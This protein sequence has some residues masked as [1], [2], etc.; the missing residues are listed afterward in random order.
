M[1]HVQHMNSSTQV[2]IA[3]YLK[4]PGRKV[5]PPERCV[6][7]AKRCLGALPALSLS[8]YLALKCWYWQIPRHRFEALICV[9]WPRFLMPLVNVLISVMPFEAVN[10]AWWHAEPP[11]VQCLSRPSMLVYRVLLSHEGMF[12]QVVLCVCDVTFFFSFSDMFF[13][14]TYLTYLTHDNFIS[15]KSSCICDTPKNLQTHQQCHL[16]ASTHPRNMKINQLGESLGDHVPKISRVLSRV[17]RYR[18]GPLGTKAARPS[19]DLP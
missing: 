12:M 6:Y 9:I 7:D 4:A 11:I 1:M 18:L 19:K 8:L 17:G 10:D 16:V 14:E 13:F 5:G 2:R 3:Q 15:D